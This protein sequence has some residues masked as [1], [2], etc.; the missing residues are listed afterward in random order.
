MRVRVDIATT[1]S[2]I[3]F[4]HKPVHLFVVMDEQP[5]DIIHTSLGPDRGLLGQRAG[6][7][8]LGFDV[9]DV[10]LRPSIDVVVWYSFIIS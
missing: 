8:I 4:V 6:A 10:H 5:Y 1:G 7:M 2:V 3:R 9:F